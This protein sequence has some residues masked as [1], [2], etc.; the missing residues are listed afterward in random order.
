MG[1]WRIESCLYGERERW[2]PDSAGDWPATDPESRDF[3][4]GCVPPP[5]EVCGGELTRRLLQPQ[6]PALVRYQALEA[7]RN[8]LIA[9]GHEMPPLPAAPVVDSIWHY[10]RACYRTLHGWA[11]PGVPLQDGPAL[12][13]SLPALQRAQRT[14]DWHKGED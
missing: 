10:D 5:C 1:V 13:G 4:L 14:G 12:V 9:A 6:R 7:R 8:E 3:R 2:R 11:R